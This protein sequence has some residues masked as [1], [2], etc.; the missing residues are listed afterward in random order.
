MET[1]NTN[2]LWKKYLEA[3]E[4]KKITKKLFLYWMNF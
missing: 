1:N 3:V 4:K 2:N